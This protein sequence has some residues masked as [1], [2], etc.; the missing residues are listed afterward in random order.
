M[1]IGPEI[2]SD[3]NWNARVH[4]DINW[5]FYFAQRRTMTNIMIP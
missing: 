4:T 1:G 2:V 3:N 5:P